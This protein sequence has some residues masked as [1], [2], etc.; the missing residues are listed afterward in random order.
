MSSLAVRFRTSVPPCHLVEKEDVFTSI[1]IP[2]ISSVDQP[3]ESRS[4]GKRSI[5]PTGNAGS[6]SHARG[7]RISTVILYSARGPP[8]STG[9]P[10]YSLIQLLNTKFINTIKKT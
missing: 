5:V 1:N 7:G 4:Q 3:S 2:A 8:L 9:K 10:R 6:V